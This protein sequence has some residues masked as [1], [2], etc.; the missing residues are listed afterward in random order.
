M[1]C[2]FFSQERRQAGYYT[3]PGPRASGS[4]PVSAL[5][6]IAVSN[7]VHTASAA[8]PQRRYSAPPHPASSLSPG[9]Q[10]RYEYEELIDQYI[11]SAAPSPASLSPSSSP[12]S[13]VRSAAAQTY[14]PVVA[15]PRQSYSS[16]PSYSSGSSSS[17]YGEATAPQNYAPSTYSNGASHPSAYRPQPQQQPRPQAV[18]LSPEYR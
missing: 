2:Y 4:L 10:K 13:A 14:N 9:P 1:S 17:G 12:A 8:S 5:K 7:G 11:P 15:S 18:S 16:S 6:P 3:F